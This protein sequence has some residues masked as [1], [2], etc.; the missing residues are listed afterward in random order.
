M[1]L[2][3]LEKRAFPATN[4]F[5]TS[6]GWNWSSGSGEFLLFRYYFSLEKI[7]ALYLN[8]PESLCFQPS[9]VEIG[10]SVPEKKIYVCRQCIFTSSQSTFIWTNL[11]SL[12]LRMLC[13]KFGWINQ[14]VLD[15]M[16]MWKGCRQTDNGQQAVRKVFCFQLWWANNISLSLKR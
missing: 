14:L 2:S 10:P 6:F 13:A 12:H 4:D 11:N 3:L 8:K 5:C 9:L 16:K 7:V 15:K 1:L